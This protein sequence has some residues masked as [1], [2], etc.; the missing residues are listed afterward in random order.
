MIV[1]YNYDS[2]SGF[3]KHYYENQ[4]GGSLPVFR[5]ATRQRGYGLGG[6][7]SSLFKG[8]APMLKT[9]A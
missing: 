8:L 6:I 1:P 3:Y 4:A 9:V 2:S 7:F 5:G